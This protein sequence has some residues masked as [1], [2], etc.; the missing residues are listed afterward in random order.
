VETPPQSLEDGEPPGTEE[1]RARPTKPGIS[2][3]VETAVSPGQVTPLVKN[4]RG[5]LHTGEQ[6]GEEVKEPEAKELRIFRAMA[7]GEMEWKIAEL[8]PLQGCESPRLA[9]KGSSASEP[10]PSGKERAD[11][12]EVS[13]KSFRAGISSGQK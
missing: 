3:L 5:T 10:G 7:P 4:P 13:E 2:R 9:P 11:L 1:N 6:Q 8:Y 12:T